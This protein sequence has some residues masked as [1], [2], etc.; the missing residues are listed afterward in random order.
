[1]FLMNA[2]PVVALQS[3]WEAFGQPR[4]FCFPDCFSESKE[5]TSRASVSARVQM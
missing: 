3:R 5:D 2:P 1:M 4:S